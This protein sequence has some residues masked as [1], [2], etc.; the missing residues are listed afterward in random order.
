ME[1]R[2]DLWDSA[3]LCSVVCV[4]T[5]DVVDQPGIGQL[6]LKDYEVFGHTVEYHILLFGYYII[7]QHESLDEALRG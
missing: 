7:R 5:M 3:V 4:H 2:A 1:T 6:L